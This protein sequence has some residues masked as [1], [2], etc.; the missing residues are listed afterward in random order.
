[1][2]AWEEERG[3]VQAGE[4]R[5]RTAVT[6][7]R[8][9][10]RHPAV[11]VLP[12]L[13]ARP[14]ANPLA[15]APATDALSAL[16]RGWADAG[17]VTMRVD[18]AGVG[19]SGGPA[20]AD[21]ELALEIDGYRA[22]LD[23]LAG[24]A[25]VDPARLFLFGLSLGGVLAPQVAAGRTVAGILVYGT[26]SRRWAD[27]LADSA[28]RQ[29]G[30]AGLR[31]EELEREAD[32]AARL[33]A[34]VLREGVSAA[35]IATDSPDLAGSIAA[36]DL[37]GD[38]LHG[39]AV[40]YFRALDA[41]EP[42]AAW[43]RAGAGALALHGEHDWIVAGDDHTRIAGWVAASGR[44]AEALTLP[45]LDHDLQRHEGLAAS[46][47]RRGRGAVD[48]APLA[49]TLSWMIG[50]HGLSAARPGPDTGGTPE[51]LR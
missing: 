50:E 40:R 7:P 44:R 2:P 8:S 23:A 42:E 24:L 4:H 15:G 25:F 39:R 28:R 27:C 18:P 6:R 34:R 13:G 43:R 49:A 36:R 17:L 22:A 20:Y 16:V 31:G 29:L 37:T 47:A 35:A 10:G 30:L 3:W 32:H 45:G 33:Y 46:F 12:G 38:R 41:I 19:E 11:M 48:G 14:L 1:M 5:L 26:T 51:V 21:A 9:E